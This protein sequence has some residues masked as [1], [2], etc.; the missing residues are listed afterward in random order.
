MLNLL[1]IDDQLDDD[2][3]SASIAASELEQIE[4]YSISK[5]DFSDAEQLINDIDP[6]LIILDLQ[7][8]TGAG[9]TDFV[10]VGT[11][12]WVWENHFC[13]IVVYSAFPEELP[14]MYES[15]P[16]VEVVQKGTTG[17][18]D[19]KES[20]TKLHPHIESV[21]KAERTIK[22]QFSVAMREVAPYAY[23]TFQDD[24]VQREDVILRSG[25]RRL[26][27][28]MDGYSKDGTRLASWEQYLCPP[29][30]LDIQL[31]D[32]LR[33]ENARLD[34]PASFRVVLTPSCDLVASGGRTPK[35]DNVLV[36]RCCSMEE[37]RGF[38]RSLKEANSSKLKSRLPN[39]LL[40]RGY[41][42]AIVPFPRLDDQIPTMAA[43]LRD[44]DFIPLDDIGISGTPILRIASIDS[45]FRE[46]ISWAYLQIACR[47][48][49][50]DRDFDSWS[51]E[52]VRCCE[53]EVKASEHE[54]S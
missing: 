29:V 20:I 42:E 2:S 41:H 5:A 3:S 4:G 53:E 43:N 32:I 39:Q 21:R 33:V 47:P 38:I 22:K 54:G 8:K 10:G 46:L 26:A 51:D 50:P 1:F 9:E 36:A 23:R 45:P 37:G 11:C 7:E 14:N 30:C 40:S 19:L 25:R 6:D 17:P 12:E 34:D 16:Y 49:L 28:L 18:K 44:L 35:V 15:H 13:P 48:G 27:A 31:A 52:I 24:A